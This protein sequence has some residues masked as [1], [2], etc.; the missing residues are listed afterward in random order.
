MQFEWWLAAMRPF[1]GAAWLFPWTPRRGPGPRASTRR[2]AR[3]LEAIAGAGLAPVHRTAV[4]NA[5]RLSRR[6]R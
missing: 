6:K 5:R 3:S 1:L 4:A 2:L